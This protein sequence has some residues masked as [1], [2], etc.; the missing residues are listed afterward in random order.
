[1]DEALASTIIYTT[2]AVSGLI[3]LVA[4]RSL[5][6]LLAT[7]AHV[8][9]QATLRQQKQLVQRAILQTFL[10]EQ[11][12]ANEVGAQFLEGD[13]DRLAF[14]LA[15]GTRVSFLI[16]EDYQGTDVHGDI[17]LLKPKQSYGRVMA[18]LVLVAMPAV[19]LIT[20]F[21]LLQFVASS[22]NVA[23]RWQSIQILQVAHVLWPPFLVSKLFQSRVTYA[24]GL[25]RSAILAAKFAQDVPAL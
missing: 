22:P 13:D 5:Q 16:K 20:G 11:S 19:I 4:L 7:E 25:T 14:Q 1:M 23:V 15:G 6:K 3:W 21:V 2:M 10:R 8:H 24:T 17:D 9:E 18:G 12:P